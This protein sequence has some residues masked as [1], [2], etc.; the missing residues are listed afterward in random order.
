MPCNVEIDAVF[1]LGQPMDTIRVIG[2]V[3]DCPTDVEGN[4][5]QVGA[6]CRSPDGPFEEVFASVDY[7]GKWEALFPMPVDGCECGSEV[8]VTAQCATQSDCAAEPFQGEIHCVECPDLSFGTDDDVGLL[9]VQFE[10]DSDG[11]V[12]VQISFEVT[13][14]TGD[15]IHVVVNCGPGGTSVS[16]GAF[17]FLPGSSGS[18]EVICRYDP[19][20][21]PSP[22][23]FVEFF[24]SDH[25]RHGCPPVPVPVPPLPDCSEGGCPTTVTLEVQDSEG[26]II[27]V[28]EI[29]CLTPGDYSIEVTEPFNPDLAYTWS[30]DGTQQPN[31]TDPAFTVTVGPEEE[32]TVSVVVD[33]PDEVCDP[34]SAAVDLEGCV[35]DCSEDLAVEVRDSQG[36]LADLNQPCLS[37]D[38]YTLEV[39]APLGPGWDFEWVINGTV[40]TGTTAPEYEI[41]LGA[42]EDVT[43]EVI[44]DGPGCPPQSAEIELEGCGSGNGGNGNGGGFF[45]CAELL[46][47]AISLL[48]VGAILTVV[49]VCTGSAPLIVAGG[50]VF[51]VGV[52]LFALWAFFC[53]AFT[54][55]GVLENLRCLLNWLAALAA[56][57][58]ILLLFLQDPACGIAALIASG[59]WAGAA[60]LLT[61]IMVQKGCTIGTCF[62]P[63]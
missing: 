51:G 16:G 18:V 49:G 1:G 59:S 2:T 24:D 27:D 7:E 46:V 57:L 11:T 9:D 43:V 25:E 3:E 62:L 41:D 15:L 31:A 20:A 32:L 34:L 48:I 6:S 58:G 8:F 52:L 4:S 12:L 10:C 36:D 22:Q 21:T 45:G 5:V 19:A 37:P 60:G 54:S 29:L 38:T 47:T 14:T 40:D 39:T 26:E 56:A 23:P 63:S 13:N 44:A 28:D 61:D 53:Q 35:L 55:C 17:G 33:H 50:A 42:G 30:V